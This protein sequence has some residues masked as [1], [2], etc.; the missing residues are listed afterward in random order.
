LGSEARGYRKTENDNDQAVAKSDRPAERIFS[1]R[2]VM[3][4][5][6]CIVGIYQKKLE[7]MASASPDLALTVVVPPAWRDDRGVTRLER[8]HTEGYRLE[9]QPIA[10]NGSFHLHFYPKL[11]RVFEAVKP[12]L[13][14]IDEEPYNFA[15]Y[16][17]NRLARRIGAKTLWFSWQNLRRRYPPPFSWMERYN[18]HHVDYALVG[19]H[20]AAEVWRA[21][22]CS[23]PMAVIP[24]F[25]VDPDLFH[26][27]SEPR[28]ASPAHI[29][30]VGRLV[31]EKGVDLL[32]TALRRVRGEWSA[33]ILGSGPIETALREQTKALDL[34]DRITFEAW[35]PSS[36]M[37]EFY[38]TVDILVVPSRTR[39]NWIEQFGRVL[40]EAM[41]SGIAVVGSN[42]GEIP[43]VVDEAGR[44]FPE[45]DAD[46]LAS[47][48]NTLV[49]NTKLRRELGWRGRER[50]KRHF[51]QRQVAE[52]T[53]S[54]YREIL[55]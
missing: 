54:I 14:H 3:V 7:E 36:Q 21:K 50:V 16:H 45:E 1:L 37:P 41:A 27:P 55:S 31:P 40:I 52:A 34:E 4:S 33:T 12:D 24:Q 26:P 18:L 17:A 38:R 29:A 32:L 35:R 11:G 20:A 2:V 8:A 44:L 13:V 22:G 46:A 53:L 42:V 15:T 23:A 30:Y 19:S 49:E 6:A 48:L 10:L 51:T 5:K 39:P 43:H 9:I 47:D 28:R 25:G